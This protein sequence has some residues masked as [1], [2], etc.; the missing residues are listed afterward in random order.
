M[1]QDSGTIT[2]L[3]GQWSSG[4]S[5]AFPRLIELAYDDLKAIA[6]RRLLAGSSEGLGTT[7]LVHEA[8]LK[9]VGRH[10]GHWE[11]RAQF[12][13]FVSR[14]MRHILV[15][16]ARR[17]HA[18]RRGG[19][20]I[21][22]PLDEHAVAANDDGVVDVLGVDEVL[23]RLSELEPRMSQ[24]VEL[25]FFGGLTVAEAAEALGTSPRTVEREWT[26]A[27]VYLLEALR[28]DGSG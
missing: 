9:L 28:G 25:R 22:I 7:A 6:H 12:Y 19:N 15:D 8:Y 11:C 4:D 3:L 18:L 17:D 24:V 20:A 14:A 21:R 26:R 13:A 10:G 2:A 27:K 23:Q 1:S 16:H 5:E